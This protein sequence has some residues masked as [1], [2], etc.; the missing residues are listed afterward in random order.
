[1]RIAAVAADDDDGWRRLTALHVADGAEH[2][3]AYAAFARTHFA[4]YR[5]LARAGLGIE[6]WAA[7]VDDAL[8]ATCQV[9]AAADWIRV[10]EVLTAPSARRRGI[11]GAL[12]GAAFA[13]SAARFPDANLLIVADA[14]GDAERLYTR[15]GFVRTGLQGAVEWPASLPR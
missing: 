15:L 12:C 3:E 9:H 11:A 8:V 4:G 6:A 7:W 5:D 14:D 13:A 1:M 2:G 10:E